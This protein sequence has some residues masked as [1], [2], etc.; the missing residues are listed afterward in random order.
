MKD[1][2]ESKFNHYN[3]TYNENC[4]VVEV[5]GEF[6]TTDCQVLIATKEA[7]KTLLGLLYE[8]QSSVINDGVENWTRSVIL[9]QLKIDIL[10]ANDLFTHVKALCCN[11][12]EASKD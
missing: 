9:G 1:K 6:I 4:E 5:N 7:L 12:R 10:A 2:K 11:L 3:P 8:K